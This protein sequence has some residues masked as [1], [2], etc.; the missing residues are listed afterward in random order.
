MEP[1]EGAPSDNTTIVGVLQQF[2]DEG[3]GSDFLSEEGPAL[4]CREC[5]HVIPVD[6]LE[7][8]A[9]RRV[10]GASDPADMAAILALECP[11]C[12]ARGTSLVSYGPT[13]S[14]VEDELLSQ[15]PDTDREGGTRAQ[16]DD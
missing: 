8:D 15:L 12:G 13:A 7:L 16:L 3:Y 2:R 9:L 11:C 14:R 5:D 6:Q 4:K 10:E 1:I